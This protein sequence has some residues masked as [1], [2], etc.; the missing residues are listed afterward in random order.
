MSNKTIGGVRSYLDTQLATLLPSGS[1]KLMDVQRGH[2]VQFAG[3]PALRYY[4]VSAREK[5]EDQK[6]KWRAVTFKLDLIYR[7][8]GVDKAVAEQVLEDAMEAVL[9]AIDQDYTLGGSADN[10]DLAADRVM[11]VDAPYGV[12]L[13]LP[14]TLVAYMNQ[15][16][17]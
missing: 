16:F 4:Y 11:E 6:D 7:L 1:D 9:N 15:F 17:A 12:S 2:K 14:I 8:S 10:T 3:Y 5:L 13:I